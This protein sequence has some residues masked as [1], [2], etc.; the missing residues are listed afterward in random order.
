[1]SVTN[2]A[3]VRE[4]KVMIIAAWTHLKRV[5]WGSFFD[6]KSEVWTVSKRKITH[7]SFNKTTLNVD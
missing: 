1:M 3:F 4:G 5:G 7:N 2:T 6:E